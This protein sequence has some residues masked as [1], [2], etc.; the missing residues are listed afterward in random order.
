MQT[1]FAERGGSNGT[2][3]FIAGDPLAKKPGCGQVDFKIVE[4]GIGPG[5]ERR[6]EVGSE[7]ALAD[8]ARERHGG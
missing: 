3:S 6:E 5:E 8:V 7:V 1:A 2:G 4:A